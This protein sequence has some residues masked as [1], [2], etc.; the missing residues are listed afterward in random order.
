MTFRGLK[1]QRKLLIF[2]FFIPKSSCLWQIF[3][4]NIIFEK[5]NTSSTKKAISK[6]FFLFFLEFSDASKLF[7]KKFG[8][9]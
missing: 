6:I 7:L 2:H 8:I 3:M 9:F 5:K 4:E 1:K